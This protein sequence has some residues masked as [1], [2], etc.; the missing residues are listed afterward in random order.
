MRAYTV[1]GPNAAGTASKTCVTVVASATA[2]PY[3]PEIQVGTDGSSPS[4]VQ[5]LYLAQRFTAAGTGTAATPEPVD[6]TDVAAVA[7]AAIT[8]SAEPTYTA[9]KALAQFA[10]NMRSWFRWVAY[11]PG[12][13]LKCPAT[14]ANGI[15]VY[16]STTQPAT[17]LA[18]SAMIVFG[19]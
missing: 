16:L 14:A 4:D 7:T 9:G 1:R 10:A 11:Q 18:G 6:A 17:S 19:E 5:V 13:E 2:R 8:H 15:G 3:I 12:Y